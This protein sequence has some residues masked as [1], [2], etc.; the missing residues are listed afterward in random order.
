M[1]VAATAVF[2]AEATGAFPAGLAAIALAVPANSGAASITA[3][4]KQR[5]LLTAGAG[6]LRFGSFA[7]WWSDC[8]VNRL[9]LRVLGCLAAVVHDAGCGRFPS[10]VRLV[11]RLVLLLVAAQDVHHT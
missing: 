1:S 3:T 5:S 7:G 6:L 8:M 10:V 2:R 4:P 9:A 11:R